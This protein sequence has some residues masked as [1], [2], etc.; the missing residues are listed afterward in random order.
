MKTNIECFN[1]DKINRLR[2]NLTEV[3]YTEDVLL[4]KAL[5]NESRVQV[6][7]LLKLESCCVCDLSQV[8]G[9]PVPTISQ[10]LR[11]LKKAKLVK[12]TKRGKFIIYSLTPKAQNL[13][14]LKDVGSA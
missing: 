11:T 2:E 6:L 12:S 4:Y 7:H 3:R 14:I 9:S 8:M 1:T 5:A 13:N 10:Y